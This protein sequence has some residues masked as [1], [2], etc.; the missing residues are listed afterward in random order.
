MELATTYMGL[1]LRNPLVASP[2]PLAY[3]VDGVQRLAESER[4][5]DRAPLAVRRAGA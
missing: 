2:S 5:R 3:T 1:E 4:R